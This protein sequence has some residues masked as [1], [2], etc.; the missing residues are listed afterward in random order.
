MARKKEVE[1]RVHFLRQADKSKVLVPRNIRWRQ[2]G[3]CLLYSSHD[4]RGSE[5]DIAAYLTVGDKLFAADRFLVDG[6]AETDGE[7]RVFL[8]IAP[9]LLDF[10]D[11]LKGVDTSDPIE[12]SFDLQRLIIAKLCQVKQAVVDVWVNA[13]RKT[14]KELNLKML[15]FTLRDLSFS[16]LFSN[17]SLITPICEAM[18][19]RDWDD[20]QRVY[21]L[22]AGDHMLVP[23]WAGT[24]A[25]Q[26]QVFMKSRMGGR[27]WCRVKDGKYVGSLRATVQ[28]DEGPL[29]IVTAN[30]EAAREQCE[31]LIESKTYG[32][33]VLLIGE[34]ESLRREAQ[35]LSDFYF[36]IDVLAM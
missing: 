34:G 20:S 8:G 17:S 29:A 5:R 25:V 24:P 36:G 27:H 11:E 16:D 18:A 6:D 13:L 2:E 10:S 31:A 4:W 35:R 15:R 22:M 9:V 26:C 14:P 30:S 32:D 7:L 21:R 28:I 3:M 23:G 33:V 12:V 19:Y 1:K